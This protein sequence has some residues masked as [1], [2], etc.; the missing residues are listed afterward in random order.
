MCECFVT[1]SFRTKL[2]GFTGFFVFLCRAYKSACEHLMYKLFGISTNSLVCKMS[3]KIALCQALSAS[4]DVKA[5]SAILI[6]WMEKAA[7]AGA[8]LATFGE[9]FLTNYDIDMKR[10]P[11]V[12]ENKDG[13]AAM[14]IA[15]AARRL[16]IAVIYGYSEVDNGDYYNSLM[17]IDKNGK[18]L[19]NYRKVHLWPG[20][21]TSSYQ[22]GDAPVV[23]NWDGLKVGL[24][25]CVD[26]CM[27]EFIATMVADGHAQLIAAGTALV[28]PPTYDKS[29]SLIVPATALQTGCYIAYTDIAGE[30]FSGMSTFCSPKG[31]CLALTKTNEEI[32]LLTTVPLNG[33]QRMPYRFLCRPELYKIPYSVELPWEIEETSDV[34][35]FFKHRAHYYDH[36]L[37]GIYNGPHI[38]ARALA[39]LVANK[40]KRVVDVA[41]GTGLVGKN[42]SSEGFT[43]II[44]LDRSEEML[45]QCAAKNVYSQL[46]CG[47][48][49]VVAKEIP[50]RYFQHCVCVG[51][52]LTAGFLDPAVS[53]AEMVR[54]VE[55]GGYILLMVNKTELQM[56]QCKAT[57]ESLEKTCSEIVEGGACECVQ[58]TTVPKY[59]DDC[60]G[61]MWILQKII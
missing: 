33:V 43:N 5:S 48:F 34:Q 4:G 39:S 15:K 16:N 22:P 36:Q 6:E 28:D 7:S 40:D 49:E 37:D 52:F 2:T 38:A 35:T 14:R 46:I 56:P 26:I 8:D 1:G 20:D 61:L 25:I 3:R 17:F 53:I 59:L 45:K 60:E 50:D 30:K 24:A 32:M 55:K 23:V 18:T 41:A 42:L 29:P 21:E 19:A 10:V 13:P 27:F 44:A 11:A 12:S 58:K 31:E 51:A 57:L 47:P 54:L 9:L